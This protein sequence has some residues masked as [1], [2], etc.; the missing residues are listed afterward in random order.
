M[1]AHQERAGGVVASIQIH[2]TIGV[3]LHVVDGRVERL[4]L[5]Q[6]DRRD[7]IVV[8]DST[9]DKIYELNEADVRESQELERAEQDARNG[10]PEPTDPTDTKYSSVGKIWMALTPEV[11]S[12]L[13]W[14]RRDGGPVL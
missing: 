6:F 8:T 10:I 11:V 2:G 7:V 13:P 9:N 4:E 14:V 12:D 1:S 5:H 3:T